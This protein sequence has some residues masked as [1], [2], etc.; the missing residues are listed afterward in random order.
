MLDNSQR[1]FLTFIEQHYLLSGT[2]PGLSLFRK[3]YPSTTQSEWDAYFTD[4]GVL[5]AA[6][7]RG[8][9]LIQ[10]ERPVG[11]LTEEQL[12]VA[13]VLLDQNDR[14]SR[15]KK[16]ADLEIP[17]LTYEAWLRDKTFSNYLKQRSENSL[18]D[19]V[20]DVHGGLLER[21]SAGDPASVKLY[22]ELTG[23][24]VSGATAGVDIAFVLIKVLEILQKYIGD[25]VKLTAAADELEGIVV[26]REQK[27][28]V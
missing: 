11:V 24:F 13:N 16:L 23:R 27:Q 12:V 7:E 3:A 15:A 9:P 18:H 21:A 26:P 25:P 4:P 8:I 14:R 28:I 1:R 19:R 20:H 22:Y 5:V 6:E 17:T 10:A 2:I